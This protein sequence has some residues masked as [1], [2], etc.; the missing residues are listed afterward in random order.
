LNAT[1][2]LEFALFNA[3]SNVYAIDIAYNIML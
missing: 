2:E 1:F 3:K